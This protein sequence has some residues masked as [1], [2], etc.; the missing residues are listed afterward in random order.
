MAL[1]SVLL[2][3]LVA[4]AAFFAYRYL[5]YPAFFSPLGK[6]PTPHPLAGIYPFWLTQKEREGCQA[7]SILE[8]HRKKG[9]VLRVE[10]NHVHVASLDGLRVV[11]HVGRFDRTDYFLPFQNYDGTTN[12]LSMMDTKAHSTRRR[13]VSQIYSKSYILSSA[14]FQKLSHII[15]FDRLLLVFDDSGESGV[16]VFELAFALSVEFTSAY[17]VGTGHDADLVRKGREKWRKE[18]LL[19]G[20]TKLLELEGHEKAAKFLENHNLEMSRK[21]AAFLSSD[22]RSESVS[23]YPVVFSLLRDAI[24]KKEGPYTP[25]QTLLLV[26]SETLDN[27]E[28]ARA[29]M[30]TSI[31]YI[32]HEISTRPAIQAALRKELMT[33]DPPMSHAPNTACAITT[34]TLRQLDALPLLNAVIMETLRL[35]NPVRMLARRVVPPGGAVIDGYFLPG[36]TEVSASTHTMHMN[37]EAFPEPNKW[38]PERW[39]G[40]PNESD[41]E[42]APN[43]PR[44]WFWTFISGSRMCVGNNFAMMGKSRI[45][46][47]SERADAVQS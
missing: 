12:L 42:R 39:L 27:M 26:A 14:E 31:T 5:L 13:M 44:R 30:G 45:A 35:R 4:A 38:D 29:A 28:A 22:E 16:D 43:D 24:P 36:G 19:A 47:C 23:T 34:T 8:A 15:L 40:L 18:Y 41:K 46:D 7:R 9:P 1:L 21:A 2:P 6:I 3:A 11:F 25:E 32:L 20:K 33:L 17:Q 10:P 37:V